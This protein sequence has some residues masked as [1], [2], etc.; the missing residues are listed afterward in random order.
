MIALL[1][2]GAVHRA[3]ASRKAR[4]PKVT[5]ERSLQRCALRNRGNALYSQTPLVERTR[6]SLIGPP[7]NRRALGGA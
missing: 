5:G 2:L 4:R 1:V 6:L 7:S 3:V